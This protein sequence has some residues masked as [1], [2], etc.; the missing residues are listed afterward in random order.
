MTIFILFHIDQQKIVWASFDKNIC[1]AKL[2]TL[3]YEKMSFKDGRYYIPYVIYDT[4]IHVKN[5][6]CST[7]TGLDDE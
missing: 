3:S 2:R 1:E 5:C 6:E 7:C 4:F